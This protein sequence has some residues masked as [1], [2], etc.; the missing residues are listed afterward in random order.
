MGTLSALAL[1][2]AVLGGCLLIGL[3][4]L[5]SYPTV[6]GDEAYIGSTA[7]GFLHGHGFR[8]SIAIGA[9]VFDNGFDLWA[10]KLGTSPYVLADLLGPTSLTGFR[11]TAWIIG[12]G[13]LGIFACAVRQLAGRRVTVAA[14][15][16]LAATWGF[17]SA[18]HFVR[19]DSLA[20]ALTSLLLLLLLRAPDRKRA[21]L[22]GALIGLSL[23]VSTGVAAITP[24]AF[25]LV[26]W[27]REDRLR[28][29]ALMA[30]GLAV[31]GAVYYAQHV[32]PDPQA[33]SNQ[34]DAIYASTYKPPFLEALSDRS[35]SPLADES[36]RYE[37]MWQSNAAPWASL[38]PLGA[39]CIS[40]LLLFLTLSRAY[41]SRAVPGILLVG[42]LAGLGLIEGNKAP[43]Y[44]WYGL[45]YALA[46]LV[47]AV[48]LVSA[49]APRFDALSPAWRRVVVAAAGVLF[50]APV[51]DLV[52][53]FDVV[54]SRSEQA[55]PLLVVGAIA[56]VVALVAAVS[57]V[58]A[59]PR[60]L[61][62]VSPA[63][64]RLIVAGA[65]AL[66]VALFA[67]LLH[68]AD[69]VGDHGPRAWP[70]LL[71]GAAV[72]LAA[73]VAAVSLFDALPAVWR[74][75]LMVAVGVLVVTPFADLIRR[76]DPLGGRSA[77]GWP[78]LLVGVTAAVI[79]LAARV[80]DHRWS[81]R[82]PI[83]AVLLAMAIG[84]SATTLADASR[85][86]REPAATA[87][88]QRLVRPFVGAKQSVMGEWIYWWAFRDPRFKFNT[89][90]WLSEFVHRE[91]FDR[92][93]DRLC[94]D[95]VM[96]DDVWLSRYDQTQ[97]L[98]K[99]FPTQ[100]PTDPGER[101]QLQQLL[102]REY[103]LRGRITV[104][105]RKIEFWER[106]GAC[107]GG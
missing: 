66:A 55:W 83:L 20:F 35:L 71:V 47:A 23:D 59:P 7:W 50:L 58:S 38:I 54:G 95:V 27:E 85:T 46:A 97:G 104:D 4:T 94:P 3:L 82:E 53:R 2:V 98:G 44:A 28:R 49:R 103:R 29:V 76:F 99:I 90:I 6:Y 67:G 101:R 31:L 70:L 22:V 102:R 48:S 56:A 86:P 64:R 25:L 78:L 8:P 24:V 80:E 19:W 63:R 65:G 15:A 73:L 105:A 61:A 89:Q 62:G 30:T 100:A 77:L 26:A 36:R 52:R 91:P 81:A 72:A 5:T 75:L 42:H 9:G 17:F 57:L 37:Y 69:P 45:T 11:L 34:Y 14:C 10:P 40:A 51:A 33:S 74:R 21:L 87:R 16:A 93:F 39:G 88:L 106:K 107:R 79:A 84:G 32:L 18:S 96:L 12:L 43:M 68:R 60:A 92:T 1:P 13:A 41:P